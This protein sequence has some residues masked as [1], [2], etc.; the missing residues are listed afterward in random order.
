MSIF[1]SLLR[2]NLKKNSQNAL[3]FNKN[4]LNLNK[5]LHMRTL[6]E[7]SFFENEKNAFITKLLNP[8]IFKINY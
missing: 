8:E 5:N 2:F 1:P 7:G 6:S 4:N 3:Y